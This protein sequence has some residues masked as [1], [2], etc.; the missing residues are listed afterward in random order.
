VP[1]AL[2]FRAAWR[3]TSSATTRRCLAGPICAHLERGS[4]MRSPGRVYHLDDRGWQAIGE[5][6]QR[7]WIEGVEGGHAPRVELERGLD[8]RDPCR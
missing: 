3:A 4:V 1:P 7:I 2:T 5:L 8:V 6:R